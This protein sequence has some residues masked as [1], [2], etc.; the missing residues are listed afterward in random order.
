M[1]CR[2]ISAI[3]DER[4]VRQRGTD[5]NNSPLDPFLDHLFSGG[6]KSQYSMIGQCITSVRAETVN[7]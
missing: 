5:K 2:R 6:L 3:P 1:L 7:I 4:H